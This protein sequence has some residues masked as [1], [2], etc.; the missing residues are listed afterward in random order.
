MDMAML[1]AQEGVH[2]G[3]YIPLI[4]EVYRPDGEVVECRFYQMCD[5][6]TDRVK[7]GSDS[8]PDDRKPSKS[9]YSTMTGFL[10]STMSA[11]ISERISF[12]LRFIGIAFRSLFFAAYLNVII[13]GGLESQL[14]DKYVSFLK[15]IVHNGRVAEPEILAQVFPEELD[16]ENAINGLE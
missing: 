10:R 14:P 9:L 13:K 11:L 8:L 16:A 6:P 7:L 15:S 12:E 4:K 5:A 2:V 1:D 3:F